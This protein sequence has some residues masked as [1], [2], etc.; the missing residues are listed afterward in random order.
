[1]V[2]FTSV[3]AA[4]GF[5]M[6][7]LA[8]QA[9]TPT[10]GDVLKASGI[11]ANGYVDFGTT[12]NNRGTNT[13]ATSGIGGIGG[14]VDGAFRLNQIGLSVTTGASEGFNGTLDLLAGKDAAAIGADAAGDIKLKQAYV[15]YANGG[16]T[17]MGG[18]FITLA[19]SEVINSS[20]NA[21][22]TRS[23]LFMTLQPLTHTGVRTS[24]SFGKMVTLTGGL[25][26]S[27]NNGGGAVDAEN[28]HNKTY[29][30]S[31]AVT[32]FDGFNNAVT[33]Y[34]GNEAASGTATNNP[35]LV[36]VVS[37]LQITKALSVG[38]NYDHARNGTV[39]GQ[40]TNGVALYG[41]FQL[42][43]ALRLGGRA[44]YVKQTNNAAGTLGTNLNAY[45]YTLTAEHAVSKNFSVLSDLRFDKNTGYTGGVLGGETKPY[46]NGTGANAGN[47]LTSLTIKG[48]YRF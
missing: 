35:L 48:I 39:A 25:L 1:M 7:P 47:A 41:S 16:L 17:V 30:A 3:L 28:N 37:S 13:G 46:G 36:D 4:A 10:L 23:I 19:G 2:K 43:D 8:S 14:A 38:L 31:V 20:Q 42:C 11:A 6:L 21:N 5:A 34:V 45:E 33:V 18:R 15:S 29:E 27:V 9:A 24:Y 44:E 26:N 12:V 32:P 40:Q 22:A